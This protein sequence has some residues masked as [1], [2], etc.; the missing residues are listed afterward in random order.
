MTDTHQRRRR[1]LTA[2]LMAAGTLG[3]AT[4]R[5][6]GD[7]T[8]RLLVGFAPGGASDTLARLIADKL[9]AVTKQV[10]IVENKAGAG[11]RLAAEALK[12]AAAD[13]QTYMLAP[14]AT[15]VFQHL[16]YP[17]S[18]LHYDMTQDF[19]GIA[20]VS[21][22]PLALVVNASTGVKS[23]KELAAWI[24]ANPDKSSFGTAG[25]GGD[26]HFNGL[27]FGK[28]A[29]L[30]LT[31]VPYRGNGPLITDLIGGQIFIGSMVAGDAL[32]YV[33]SG[34]LNYVG[35][36]APQRSP[37]LM[38]VPTLAEQGFDTGGG[39]GWM[40]IWGPA[41]LP[42]A[43][44]VRM[45]VA[46][47]QVLSNKDVKSM[48]LTRFLMVPDFLPGADVD[49]KLAAELAHWGPVIKASGFSPQQ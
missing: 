34:K 27:Q 4:T 39:N 31:V 48:M 40:G 11:G 37:L 14:N 46:L 29:G 44:I 9:A 16:N 32:Q 18:V 2:A 20:Q 28:R 42:K 38:D 43:E 47:S 17:T 45:Q 25:A 7:K 13:G 36:Y 15:L 41:K 5:A 49:K 35:I 1:L 12:N 24:R 33:R 23:A 10:V 22:Y 3:A 8:M 6:Q 19:A 30:A 26:S 21:S